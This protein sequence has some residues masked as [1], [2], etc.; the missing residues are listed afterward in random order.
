MDTEKQ[1]YRPFF[2]NSALVIFYMTLIFDKNGRG[3]K[4]DPYTE[5]ICDYSC[6]SRHT[7]KPYSE[8]TNSSRYESVVAILP[9]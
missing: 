6:P 7:L 8:R 5:F 1:N 4:A 3:L 9:K 2:L